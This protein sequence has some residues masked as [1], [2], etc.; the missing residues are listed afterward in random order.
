M[1]AKAL[2]T[3]LLVALLGGCLAAAKPAAAASSKLESTKIYAVRVGECANAYTRPGITV[4]PPR[5]WA[6]YDTTGRVGQKVAF[7][8][9]MFRQ[10][11][12]GSWQLM[13]ER[14]W[15]TGF[16]RNQ[17]PRNFDPGNL[18]TYSLGAY[19][20][21]GAEQGNAAT[22]FMF[23]TSYFIDYTGRYRIAMDMYWY[24]NQYSSAR[25]I[26]KWLPLHRELSGDAPLVLDCDVTN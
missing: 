24:A 4:D 9:R 15:E 16:A 6:T 8:S 23:N 3:I 10:N 1:K 5:M 7:K 12:D 13:G 18:W 22:Q 17:A 2:N 20:F 14:R 19:I 26:S 25:H 21:T 11:D